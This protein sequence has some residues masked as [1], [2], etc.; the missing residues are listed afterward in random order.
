[1]VHVVCKR[2]ITL[3]ILFCC[4]SIATAMPMSDE[5]AGMHPELTREE[6]QIKAKELQLRQEV[7]QLEKQQIQLKKY[8]KALLFKK[9]HLQYKWVKHRA[10]K[11]TPNAII[12]GFAKNKPINICRAQY[13][14]GDHPG[15]LVGNTCVITYRGKAHPM[16]QYDVLTGKA[17]IKWRPSNDLYRYQSNYAAPYIITPFPVSNKTVLSLPI[18]GGTEVTKSYNRAPAFTRSLYICRCIYANRIH[19]GKIVTGNCN[20]AWQ[21]KEVKVP[22]YEA[23][24]D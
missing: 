23:L 3:I 15:Q 21:K 16:K 8:N 17:A 10:N 2:L 11:K 19:V 24:F 4:S 14:D 22:T 9:Q 12:A 7:L 6:L 5:E 1:M 20:I 13:Q 18:Q